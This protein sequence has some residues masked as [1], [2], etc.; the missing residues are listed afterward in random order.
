M[1]KINLEVPFNSFQGKVCKH[2]KI[3]FKKMYGKQFT[4][5]ICN[6]YTG[7]LSTAQTE[8]RTKFKNAWNAVQTLSAADRAAYVAAY[9][10]NP[11][12]YA[13]LNGYIF[14]QEYAKL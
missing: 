14:A 2:S 7:D 11:G 13:T 3:I 8:H 6:P 10:S 5:Q 9:K 4:S 12:K 1:S